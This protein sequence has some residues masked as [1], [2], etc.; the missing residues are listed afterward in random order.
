MSEIPGSCKQACSLAVMTTSRA[1]IT[2]YAISCGSLPRLTMVYISLPRE[3]RTG[4][5]QITGNVEL[6]L[7]R[8]AC[9]PGNVI[10][11]RPLHLLE[12]M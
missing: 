7:P 9:L 8:S 6:T 4:R 1:L 3:V 10:S 12:T 11:D 2:R 5:A